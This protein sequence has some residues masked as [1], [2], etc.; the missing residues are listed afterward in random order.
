MRLA[1]LP[2]ASFLGARL[3]D[4]NFS[5]LLDPRRSR[6]EGLHFYM[7]RFPHYDVTDMSMPLK[8]II[9]VIAVGALGAGAW[10]L[11][12]S[13]KTESGTPSSETT[14]KESASS[15]MFADLMARTGS[16]QCH[17]KATH[18]QGMSEGDVFINDGNIRGDFVA[19]MAGRSINTSFISREGYMYTWSDMLPQGMKVKVEAAAGTSGGQGIDPAT[20]VEYSCE[21]W[22]VDESKFATPSDM[23]FF[24]IGTE[25]AG[26]FNMP[27]PR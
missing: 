17:T 18:E 19:S 13:P 8:I 12:S 1:F 3:G 24:E 10:F 14:E 7:L 6:D 26:G 21:A 25:G 5:R 23:E 22:A 16:W 27:L 11:T 15:G 2:A 9:A 20:P 4:V